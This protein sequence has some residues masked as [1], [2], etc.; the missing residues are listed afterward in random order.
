M[1]T[2][3]K[4]LSVVI[5]RGPRLTTHIELQCRHL[6]DLYDWNLIAL[7]K[8]CNDAD[9]TLVYIENKWYSDYFV[10]SIFFSASP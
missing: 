6:D 4:H 10:V 1:T 9:I 2:R 5:I 8:L 7:R 3:L